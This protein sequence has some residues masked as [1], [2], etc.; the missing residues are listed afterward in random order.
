MKKL[1]ILGKEIPV[2]LVVS[3]LIIGVGSATLLAYYGTITAQ[4]TV[5]QSILLDNLAWP[6]SQVTDTILEQAPGG[7]TFCFEHTLK[8]QMSVTGS[9]NFDSSC[10]PDCSG[11]T[12]TYYNSFGTVGPF[13][14]S[15]D[16]LTT[17]YKEDLSQSIKWKV[18]INTTG[19]HYG[20]GLVLAN[21]NDPQHPFQ[22]WMNNNNGK[23]QSQTL[24]L[25]ET[26]C[27]NGPVVDCPS[28]VCLNGITATPTI[29]DP[30]NPDFTITV[31]KSLLG[32]IGATFKWA[33]HVETTV[34]GYYPSTWP[35]D[36][37]GPITKYAQESTVGSSLTPPVPIPSKTTKDF[38]ICYGFAQNIA[39]GTYTITTG[40]TP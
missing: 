34:Q 23:W 15:G 37:C 20:V 24:H 11:I 27:W 25:D 16:V 17:I 19:A 21:L 3:V 13:Y 14:S 12:K 1:R 33:M 36:W 4:V 32:G 22:V 28:G 5:Q 2:I 29:Y 8:N 7:E 31:P 26:P 9:V 40:I 35:N 10:T 30:T 39:P 6:N 18:H 38:Y